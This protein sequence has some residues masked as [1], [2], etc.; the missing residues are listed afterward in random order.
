MTV[1]AVAGPP[2]AGKSTLSRRLGDLLGLPV[3]SLDGDRAGTFGRWG[4]TPARAERVYQDG[5]A[6]AL[7][8]YESLFEAF[9]FRRVAA[10]HAQSCVLDLSGGVLTQPQPPG[11]AAL[12]EALRDAAALVVVL[13]HPT[14]PA[15]A[16]RTLT[17]RLLARAQDEESEVWLK[18]GGS[19]LLRDLEASAR[20]HIDRGARLCDTTT[21]DTA[22]A[23]L[24]AWG[25]AVGRLGTD[26]GED[27]E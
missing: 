15:A 21:H 6:V 22:A 19:G 16:H 2:G 17:D 23:A 12:R 25:T 10:E 13:P 14:D 1:V 24:R 26:T 20:S 7:H 18:H 3:V 9:A 27:R 4:Y 5:G 8:R 11:A